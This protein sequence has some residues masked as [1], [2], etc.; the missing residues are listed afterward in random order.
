MPF[1]VSSLKPVKL[2]L[3]EDMERL[4]IGSP[5]GSLTRIREKENLEEKTSCYIQI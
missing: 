3:Q 2:D 5:Q 1:S 4:S